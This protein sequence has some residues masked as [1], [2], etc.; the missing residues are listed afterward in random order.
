[1]AAWVG[2][3][4]GLGLAGCQWGL[5]QLGC[6][7][8]LRSSLTVGAWIMVTGG[9]HLDGA[10]D[11]ADGLAVPNPERRLEVMSDSR[12]GAFG[13]MAAILVILLK[14]SAMQDLQV[15]Q[16]YGLVLSTVW[17]RWAQFWA[18]TR[19]PYLKAE[20]KGALHRRHLQLPQD[21]WPNMLLLMTIGSIAVIFQPLAWPILISLLVGNC[22]IA[23]MV[24][25]WF[26]HQLK[27][28]T[29]DTYGAIVEWTEALTICYF[30]ILTK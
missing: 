1:W 18:I 11:T 14:V 28:M 8:L 29:G 23:W 13:V 19:Y 24:S 27:G 10:M 21:L 26:Q 9:L 3:A 20:G 2:F 7:D 25:A 17:G 5:F 4:I 30:S 16:F 22:I 15:L 6:A 12:T